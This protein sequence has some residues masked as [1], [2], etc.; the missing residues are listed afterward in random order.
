MKT[1]FLSLNKD[2]FLD[3]AGSNIV[4]K[5]DLFNDIMYEIGAELAFMVKDDCI[6]DK[7]K[8]ITDTRDARP[9]V[10]AAIVDKI[11]TLVIWKLL[12]AEI[13]EETTFAFPDSYVD[14]LS[15][16]SNRAYAE[17][18]RKL[19][20]NGNSVTLCLTD[21]YEESTTKKFLAKVRDTVI[22]NNEIN[23]FTIVG[24]NDPESN[25]VKTII[26][27]RANLVFEPYDGGWLQYEIGYALEMG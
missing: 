8:I 2:Y 1:L 15:Y 24:N 23:K 11:N 17:I 21:I 22:A 7:V 25:I 16:N 4:L 18:G 14:W 26:D 3:S 20:E 12:L 6:S 27:M 10:F 19:H 9:E 13:P 5:Y